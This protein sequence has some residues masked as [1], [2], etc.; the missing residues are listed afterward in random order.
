MLGTNVLDIFNVDETAGEVNIGVSRK[1]GD[2]GVS[3]YGSVARITFKLN[4]T[5]AGST[6]A[7]FSISDVAAIDA[8]F[9]PITLT[10]Q[11]A[12][13]H[14][15]E[16]LATPVLISPHDNTLANQVD[17]N[18]Q[19]GTVTGA[20]YYMFELDNNSDFSSP[21]YTATTTDTIYNPTSLYGPLANSLPDDTYYWRVKACDTV[22]SN[23]SEVRSVR[24]T[25][26]ILKPKVSG[27]HTQGQ[28]FW[29][30]GGGMQVRL[31]S[32]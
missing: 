22:D 32:N 28:E 1:A 17:L 23:W 30:A 31:I 19:W 20:A 3:G 13:I 11:T 24:V 29:V 26:V 10:P 27:T 14:V 16:K 8:A 18:Y 25:T 2:T 7:T 5:V 6:T 4:D 21:E 15:V 9:N 12:D